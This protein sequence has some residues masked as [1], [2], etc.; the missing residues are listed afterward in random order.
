VLARLGVDGVTAIGHS[1]GADVAVDLAEHSDRVDR[2]VV[3]T[4]AP[5]YSDATLPRGRALMTVP[6]VGAGLHGVAKVLARGMLVG[7]RRFR[8][9]SPNRD[10]A[11]LAVADI[12]ALDTAMFRVVLV[13]RGERMARHP[14]D[15]QIAESGK[16]ALVLLG[17]RDQ[18]YGDRSAGRYRA[19]GA[20]VEILPESGHQPLIEMPDR[21]VDLIRRFVPVPSGPA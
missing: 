11:E 17:G 10:L 8:P 16:P 12:R 14:L 3:I 18:H 20:Q 15:A 9:D 13:E 19:A 5:D 2:V 4:Q 6:V 7:M 1:F 21:V